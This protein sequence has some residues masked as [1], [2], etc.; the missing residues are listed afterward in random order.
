MDLDTARDLAA[1]RSRHESLQSQVARL[2]W[3]VQWGLL[4]AVVFVP[5]ARL[6]E[7]DEPETTSYALF[8]AVGFFLSARPADLGG[9]EAH[10]YAVP[11]GRLVTIIGLF[12]ILVGVLATAVTSV[13]LRHPDATRRAVLALQL[14]ASVLLLGG[15]AAGVGLAWLPDDD[16][17]AIRPA[18]GLLVALAAA[19]W[20]Y[21]SAWSAKDR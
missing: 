18:W 7:D 13:L 6:V 15:L 4:T 17:L 11:G 9:S 8:T 14:S 3:L 5:L 19:V 10:P 20:A 12:L 21:H 2:Q 1:L 16:D